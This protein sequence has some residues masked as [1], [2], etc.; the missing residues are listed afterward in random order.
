MAIAAGQPNP[1]SLLCS[2]CRTCHCATST[3][4]AATASAPAPPI[5]VLAQH[6]VF[7][8][9]AH[10]PLAPAHK[11][12]LSGTRLSSSTCNHGAQF[13][14]ASLA[15]QNM[16]PSHRLDFGSKMF[17]YAMPPPCCS[18]R[19]CEAGGTCGLSCTC[20]DSTPV[21]DK[22]ICKVR[23]PPCAALQPASAP[24]PGLV[25]QLTTPQFQTN[26]HCAQPCCR[27]HA[28]LAAPVVPAL[29]L[30]A[31]RAVPRAHARQGR[32][33]GCAYFACGGRLA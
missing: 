25:Q 19:L 10:I 16:R 26:L 18:Q 20:P 17:N 13:A 24:S 5:S 29:A 31:M 22:G 9:C 6:Q 12:T 15:S 11:K 8:R 32:L 33:R 23:W 14:F 28:R 7:V 30:G 21:C 2:K 1:G 3:G 4:H 27:R